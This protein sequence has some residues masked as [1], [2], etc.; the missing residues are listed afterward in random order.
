MLGKTQTSAPTVANFFKEE[1][2]QKSTLNHLAKMRQCRG[3]EKEHA[4]DPHARVGIFFLFCNFI[5]ILSDLFILGDWAEPECT[6]SCGSLGVLKQTRPCKPKDDQVSCTKAETEEIL[7]TPCNRTTC[8]VS[9]GSTIILAVGLA[10][11]IVIICLVVVIIKVITLNPLPLIEQFPGS[12]Y[13]S[14]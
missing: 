8:P 10:A 5:S 7:G 6:E 13:P 1:L 11:L 12:S 9:I 3:L 4:T 14:M 2:A